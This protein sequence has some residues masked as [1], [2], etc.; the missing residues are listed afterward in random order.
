MFNEKEIRKI[1]KAFNETDKNIVG[2][3]KVLSDLNRYRIF[4]ILSEQ[5][6]LSIGN[7][8]EILEISLPLA[9]QHIKILSQSNLIH[10]ERGGK[11]VLTKLKHDN[12]FVP[13]II[14]TIHEILK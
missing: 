2:I 7:I 10:K 4:R 8:A 13:V 5:P 14:K 1:R 9:S 6:K 12:P 3:F 11:N